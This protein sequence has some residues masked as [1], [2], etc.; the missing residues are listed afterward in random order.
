MSDWILEQ[1]REAKRR[2]GEGSGVIR[3]LNN[4]EYRNTIRDLFAGMDFDP[5]ST[6]LDDEVVDGFDNDGARTFTSSYSLQEY[7]AAGKLVAERA[8]VLGERPASIRRSWPAKEL[9]NTR[10]FAKKKWQRVATYETHEDGVVLNETNY[11]RLR[12]SRFVPPRFRVPASGNYA[13]RV[14]G[15]GISADGAPVIVGFD[16]GPTPH[17]SVGTTVMHRIA[18]VQFALDKMG[19]YEVVSHLDAGDFLSIRFVN[20]TMNRRNKN[21]YN[22]LLVHSLE[23]EGPLSEEWPPARTQVVT[24]PDFRNVDDLKKSAPK[25][26]RRAYRRPPTLDEITFFIDLVQRRL[27]EN[28]SLEESL[29]LA[30]QYVL[31]SPEF[32]YL[33]EKPGPLDD[34]AIASR[35]SYFLWSS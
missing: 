19:T 4:N 29:E 23:I 2:A 3:R 35:L 18:N 7:L 14:K 1:L 21:P 8:I 10:E 6:F 13:I 27:K 16:K 17:T 24:G 11:G 32:L 33:E 30:V 5:T 15:Y 22:R 31:A 9:V 20:G 28:Y 34:Y 25:F 12:G 26:L